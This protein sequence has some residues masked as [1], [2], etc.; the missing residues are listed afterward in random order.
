MLPTVIANFARHLKPGG[1][2]LVSVPSTNLPLQTKHYQ[3]FTPDS[4]TQLFAPH[5]HL[6][7]LVGFNQPH[8]LFALYRSLALF[9]YPL[10]TRLPFVYPYFRWLASYFHRRVAPAP[11]H[12]ALDLIAVYSKSV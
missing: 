12:Q 9:L 2:C 8:R 4:L 3:H 5:F 7:T 6:K 11:P 1:L 10:R